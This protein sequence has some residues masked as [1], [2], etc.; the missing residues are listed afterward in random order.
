MSMVA[1][2]YY[3]VTASQQPTGQA[4]PQPNPE[5]STLIRTTEPAGSGPFYTKAG[6]W[7]VAIILAAA[8]LI[9]FSVKLS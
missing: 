8:G 1:S 3:G 2:S 5:G 6:F 7:I 9:H 4:G